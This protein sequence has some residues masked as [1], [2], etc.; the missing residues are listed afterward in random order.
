M[1]CL[2]SLLL[3]ACFFSQIFAVSDE[4]IVIP[5]N[6]VCRPNEER[7]TNPCSCVKAHL[8]SHL[9]G[10]AHSRANN[11]IS[12]KSVLMVQVRPPQDNLKDS[13]TNLRIQ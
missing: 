10:L 11:K 8:P 5:C 1:N 4:K 2:L 12:D 9:G 7:I 3:L 6:I 13:E